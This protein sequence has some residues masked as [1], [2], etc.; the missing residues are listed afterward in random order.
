MAVEIARS[1]RVICAQGFEFRDRIRDSDV[2]F[3][4]IRVGKRLVDQDLEVRQ[5]KTHM[6]DVTDNIAQSALDSGLWRSRKE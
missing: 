4:D 3:G 2:D 5:F 6:G 1:A